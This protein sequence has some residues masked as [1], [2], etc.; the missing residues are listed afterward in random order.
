MEEI[1]YDQE[2][3]ESD[4]ELYRELTAERWTDMS[5]KEIA[6]LL[7]V[8]VKTLRKWEKGLIDKGYITIEKKDGKTIR[9]YDY[10]KLNGFKK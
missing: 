5:D 10:A 8:H 7:K 9:R 4:P 3:Y 2:L 1:I 6:A